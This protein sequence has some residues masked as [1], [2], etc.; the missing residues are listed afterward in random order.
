[1]ASVCVHFANSP[2][3]VNTVLVLPVNTSAETTRPRTISHNIAETKLYET[4][5]A[6]VTALCGFAGFCDF[7]FFGGP[8][9]M[10]VAVFGE[11][12]TEDAALSAVQLQLRMLT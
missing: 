8:D 9:D 5:Y 6:F 12:L 7:P 1:M 4:R 3:L 11:R 2:V 10:I